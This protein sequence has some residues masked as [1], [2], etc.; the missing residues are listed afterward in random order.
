[1]ASFYRRLRQER[2]VAAALRTAM[3]QARAK[4]PHLY[5]WAPFV[6]VGKAFNAS[7]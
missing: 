3:L 6:I 5:Y 2:E 7:G 1:M 4:N